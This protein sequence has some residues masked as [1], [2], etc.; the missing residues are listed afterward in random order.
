M[1][2]LI[3]LLVLFSAC[4]VKVSTGDDEKEKNKKTEKPGRNKNKI[5]NG[6]EIE[7]IGGLK[8]DQAFLT[9]QDDGSFLD[10]ENVTTINKPVKLNL[11]IKGWKGDD[12]QVSLD[13]EQKITTSEGDLLMHKKNMLK[14]MKSISSKD[15]EY[16]SFEF[17]ITKLNKIFDYFLV[18]AHAW[19][20]EYDQSVKA[21]F[22]I[23]VE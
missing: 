2:Y 6:I 15:A 4:E 16:L 1:R 21:S 11:V 14:D 18:E 19:N 9:Y 13:A 23:H 17:V 8:V 20:T 7:T 3:L 12:A 22:K 10:E 5:R